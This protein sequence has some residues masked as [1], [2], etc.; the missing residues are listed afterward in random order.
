M[1]LTRLSNQPSFSSSFCASESFYQSKDEVFLCGDSN[2]LHLKQKQRKNSLVKVRSALDNDQWLSLLTQGKKSFNVANIQ[3]MI[4]CCCLWQEM[5]KTFVEFSHLPLIARKIEN[6][7]MKYQRYNSKNFAIKSP[8]FS[9]SFNFCRVRV[10][11]TKM[12]C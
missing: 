7:K 11:T 6:N 2:P 10:C 12:F 4:L 8:W 1:G 3:F 5:V 9:I